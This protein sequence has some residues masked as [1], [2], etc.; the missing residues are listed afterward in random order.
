MHTEKSQPVH[1]DLGHNLAKGRWGAVVQNLKA[2][3]GH[4]HLKHI[5]EA[6][7]G[8]IAQSRPWKRGS[9]SHISFGWT[10]PNATPLF[11][12]FNNG[13]NPP[14]WELSAHGLG[15][16][17][18]DLSQ[19]HLDKARAEHERVKHI[20]S[21]VDSVPS[22][23]SVSGTFSPPP[24]PEQRKSSDIVDDLAPFIPYAA[25]QFLGD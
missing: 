4:P 2:M 8:H 25:S 12:A 10:P 13:V 23:S 19:Q 20:Y 1:T 15:F 18:A 9:S 5:I 16:Y 21:Y 6:V 22:Y 7:R 17:G 24:K 11:R 14:G 3:K